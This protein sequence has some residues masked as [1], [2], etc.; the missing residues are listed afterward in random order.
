[1]SADD[2]WALYR[3]GR[4]VAPEQLGRWHVWEPGQ[5]E[6]RT[7]CGLKVPTEPGFRGRA[8]QTRLTAGLEIPAFLPNCGERVS[9]IVMD[10]QVRSEGER[11][12]P[13]CGVCLYFARNGPTPSARMEERFGPKADDQTP[14]TREG[15]HNL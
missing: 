14:F 7:L 2:R 11:N 6:G 13:V 9:R 1:M 10:G 12:V 4:D 3:W 15:W 8:V 5:N